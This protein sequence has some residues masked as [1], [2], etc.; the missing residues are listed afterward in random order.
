M[1]KEAQKIEEASEI[2]IIN[3]QIKS[4]CFLMGDKL[5]GI[6]LYERDIAQLKKDVGELMAKRKEL[7]AANGSKDPK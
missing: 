2:E 1:E 7:E 3:N 4:L 6:E 5:Y